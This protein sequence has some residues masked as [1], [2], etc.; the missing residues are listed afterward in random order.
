[1]KQVAGFPNSSGTRIT[2]TAFSLLHA[3]RSGVAASEHTKTRAVSIAFHSVPHQAEPSARN[4][5][6]AAFGRTSPRPP[7]F[8]RY[9]NATKGPVRLPLGGSALAPELTRREA[10]PLGHAGQLGPY[11]GGIDRRLA[12]PGAI[13]AIAA[14]DDV[15]APDQLGV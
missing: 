13:A 1:M 4:M 15:L 10:R 8:Q 7:L 2:S 9:C 14:G 11:H 3:A 6:G 5:C 12:D